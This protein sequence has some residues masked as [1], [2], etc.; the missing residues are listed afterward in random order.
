MPSAVQAAPFVVVLVAAA[1]VDVDVI[2]AADLGSLLQA[3]S[4]LAGSATSAARQARRRFIS[5]R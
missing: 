3:A 1:V 5:P 4:A 2:V